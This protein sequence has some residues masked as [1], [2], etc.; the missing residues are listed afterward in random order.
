MITIENVSRRTFLKGAAAL[1]GSFALGLILDPFKPHPFYGN[2]IG[3]AEAAEG[4]APAPGILSPNVFVSIDNTGMVTIIAH[5]SE[6]GQGVRTS[7]PMILADELEADWSRVKIEQAV[8]DKIYGNQY[9]D[10]SRSVRHN[11]ERMR[12]FGAVTRTMLVQAAAQQWGVPASECKAQNHKVIHVPSGKSLDYG[13]LVDT[14]AA[15]PVPTAKSVTLKDPKDFRYIGKP[16]SSV[17]FPEHDGGQGDLRHRRQDAGHGVRGGRALPGDLR[18]SQVVRSQRGLEGPRRQEGGGD[19]AEPAPDRVQH[20]GRHRRDR[21][22]HLGGERRAQEAQ[23]R[24]GLRGQC[25][26][27]LRRVPQGHGGREHQRRQ[28]R[29]QRGRCAGSARRR[30]RRWWRRTSTY[31]TSR[32]RPWSRR[33]PPLW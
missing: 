9:T 19:P 4:V 11:Y 29:A 28:G 1:G 24:M 21:N 10:G 12:E 14:A 5:R 16:I 2:F 17:D 31:L 30:R 27:R 15:L 6:M 32:M 18:Q 20:P 33:R 13:Q 3:S 22:Q 23:D 8:G 25:G 7:V 26:L